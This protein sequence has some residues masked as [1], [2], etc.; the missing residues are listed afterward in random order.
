MKKNIVLSTTSRL[1]IYIIIITA[2][3]TIPIIK[4]FHFERTR[5]LKSDFTNIY[6]FVWEVEQGL[7]HAS[8]FFN[9]AT[10]NMKFGHTK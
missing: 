8:V 3:F 6:E 1:V 2:I 5:Y 10:K 4:D 9:E 7:C